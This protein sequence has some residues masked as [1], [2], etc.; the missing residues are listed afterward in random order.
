MIWQPPK[1][2]HIPPSS[3]S[4]SKKCNHFENCK[5]NVNTFQPTTWAFLDLLLCLYFL[6]PCETSYFAKQ[7][8]S[9]CTSLHYTQNGNKSQRSSRHAHFRMHRLVTR[10]NVKAQIS[11][12]SFLNSSEERQAAERTNKGTFSY[13]ISLN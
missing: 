11:Q 10:V 4:T 5:Y 6:C 3:I 13:A 8:L 12:H 2:F 1:W 9:Q 7:I